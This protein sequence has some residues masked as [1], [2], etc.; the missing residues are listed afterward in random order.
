MAANTLKLVLH[1]K[2]NQLRN[3]SKSK[4]HISSGAPHLS[5]YIF[6]SESSYFRA[7]VL[8]ARPKCPAAEVSKEWDFGQTCSANTCQPQTGFHA[9]VVTFPKCSTEMRFCYQKTLLGAWADLSGSCTHRV[10]FTRISFQQGVFFSPCFLIPRE[11]TAESRSLCSKPDPAS[12]EMEPPACG[13]VSLCP[14]PRQTARFP[15][16]PASGECGGAAAESGRGM[17]GCAQ[18]GCGSRSGSS[19]LRCAAPA[20]DGSGG[21]EGKGFPRNFICLAD[22]KPSIRVFWEAQIDVFHR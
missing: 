9:G 6:Q 7:Q 16:C 3:S 15:E 10:N 21:R 5:K 17:R 11:T 4:L 13:C 12:Q 19:V 2:S 14:C 18:P 1:Q 8:R 20:A 22:T